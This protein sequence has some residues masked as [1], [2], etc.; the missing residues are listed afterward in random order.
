M[1]IPNHLIPKMNFCALKICI[2]YPLLPNKLP[3]SLAVTTTSII[4]SYEGYKSG[5][6]LVGCFWL[7]D[8]LEVALKASTRFQSSAD[9]TRAGRSHQHHSHGCWWEASA[10]RYVGLSTGLFEFHL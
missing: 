7:R 6:D 9:L 8:A 2:S 1:H 3:Q 10:F 5:S 4:T